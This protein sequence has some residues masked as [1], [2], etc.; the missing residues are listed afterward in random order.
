MLPLLPEL[1]PVVL[2]LPVEP[3]LL[4]EL[5]EELEALLLELDEELESVLPEVV[6]PES[7]LPVVTPAEVEPE[8]LEPESVPDEVEPESL[9]PESVP[10]DVEPESLEPESVPDE[11][12]P[13]S[14][15]TLPLLPELAVL[16]AFPDDEP[17]VAEVLEPLLPSLVA[18]ALEAL[19]VEPLALPDPLPELPLAPAA[20]VLEVEPLGATSDEP[21]PRQKSSE[22]SRQRRRMHGLPGKW[23][24]RKSVDDANVFL[25]AHE[26][27]ERT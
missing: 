13:E 3:L 22:P 1:P 26:A 17:C 18:P 4:L 16:P 9:E 24:T 7:V 15:P 23:A 2:P 19:A 10:A 6:E 11:V 21:H 27:L 14:L 12:E 25:S 8:S 5:D 20:P